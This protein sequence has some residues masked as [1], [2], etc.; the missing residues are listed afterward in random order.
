MNPKQTI[1]KVMATAVVV[2]V[3]S[4]VSVNAAHADSSRLDTVDI[5]KNA[6]IYNSLSTIQDEAS[7]IKTS[8][9][10][11]F[12]DD[13]N[14]DKQIAVLSTEGSNIAAG[15]KVIPKKGEDGSEAGYKSAI[16][17]WASSYHVSF[18]MI[19]GKAKFYKVA[20]VNTIDSKSVTSTVG[21]NVGGDVTASETPSGKITGGATW[22]TSASYN[23][24][25]YK[26]ILDVD[27]DKKVQWRV[28]F[29]SAMNQGY[30]PYTQDS[31]EHL[32][33]GNQLF[34][35]SRNGS[36]YAKD[37][38]I[39]SDQMPSLASYS[40]SPGMIAV[41]TAEKDE[42]VSEVKVKYERTS[43]NYWM[44]WYGGYGNRHGWG[45]I[46][47]WMGTNF[48][49]QYQVHSTNQYK[50]DWKNHKLIEKN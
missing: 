34:M 38:F 8:L 24:A 45:V 18:E 48:K 40:F 13:P 32:Y 3:C 35:K 46:G 41:I 23:Q 21:Y 5:G 44:D 15:K 14:S 7:Q 19:D 28:P 49:E 47:C 10:I 39:S 2:N 22:S 37:N 6:K 42:N 9:H 1:M 29:V 17:Q 25:D 20:P 11:S 33:N 30:G 36:D 50:I 4:M 31:D 43:D 26:T 12:I 16:L 27:T